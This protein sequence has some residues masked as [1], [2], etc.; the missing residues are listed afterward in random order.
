M[1]TYLFFFKSILADA[2]VNPQCKSGQFGPVGDDDKFVYPE[3]V[4]TDPFVK[5]LCPSFCWLAYTF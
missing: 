2:D 4:C 1:Q 5:G 3:F